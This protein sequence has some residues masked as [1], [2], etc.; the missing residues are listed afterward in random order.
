MNALSILSRVLKDQDLTQAIDRGKTLNLK[1]FDDAVK[2]APAYTGSVF[3]CSDAEEEMLYKD[4]Q[5]VNTFS[6]VSRG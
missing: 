5:R 6:K 4:T 3:S 1:M 2:N